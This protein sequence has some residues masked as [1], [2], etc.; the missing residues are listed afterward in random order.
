MYCIANVQNFKIIFQNSFLPGLLAL[1]GSFFL[2]HTHIL[3]LIVENEY[4]KSVFKNIL[5]CLARSREV[6]LH[7]S[8]IYIHIYIYYI[9]R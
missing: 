2:S 7:L 6:P 3:G 1:P 8:I 9:Y 5:V 4:I